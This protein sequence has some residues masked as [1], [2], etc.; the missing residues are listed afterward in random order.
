[1]CAQTKHPWHKKAKLYQVP[2]GAK[3]R[4]ISIDLIG[5]LPET[6]QKYIIVA[7][8]S[9]IGQFPLPDATT[10]T[11]AGALVTQVFTTFGIPR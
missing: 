10:Q 1:M 6:G 4:R 7:I 2:V 3:I 8:T 9:R 5:E 11:V